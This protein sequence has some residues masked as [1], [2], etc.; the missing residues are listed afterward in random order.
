MNA[1]QIIPTDVVRKLFAAVDAGDLAA[2]AE[3]VADDVHM[4]FGN[5]EPTED[6]AAF[7]EATKTIF[8]SF[9]AIRHDILD[10]WQVD[11]VTVVAVMDVHYTRLDGREVTL[12]CCNTFR[13]R[14]SAIR[15]YRVF[16]DITPVTAP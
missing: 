13:L 4:R 3:L 16:V 5:A 15:D 9:A 14:D 10:V 11:A 1:L 8:S 12:P 6:K 7:F 2:V